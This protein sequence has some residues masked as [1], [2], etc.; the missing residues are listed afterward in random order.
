MEKV[1]DIIQAGD[2]ITEL[3]LPQRADTDHSVA[4]ED[5]SMAGEEMVEDTTE[6]EG[7]TDEGATDEGAA[8]EGAADE[9]RPTVP[10]AKKT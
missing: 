10:P 5:L 6:G 7:A 3:N 8:D 2:P 1:L 4:D 9:A